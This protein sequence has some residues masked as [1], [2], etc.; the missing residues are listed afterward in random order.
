MKLTKQRSQSMSASESLFISYFC[1]S[2]IKQFLTMRVEISKIERIS[3]VVNSRLLFAFLFLTPL[4]TLSSSSVHRLKTFPLYWESRIDD[5]NAI[6]LRELVNLVIERN[7]I[8]D[9]L[10]NG[11]LLRSEKVHEQLM[12]RILDIIHLSANVEAM[13]E[14]TV[15]IDRW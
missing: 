13:L 6:W 5:D 15:M 8:I 3:L 4:V 14:W 9:R 11:K 2:W 10:Q 7:S 1:H 12:R